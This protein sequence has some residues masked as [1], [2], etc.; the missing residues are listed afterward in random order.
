M[1][2]LLSLCQ[3]RLHATDA[4]QHSLLAQKALKIIKEN[5]LD[6]KNEKLFSRCSPHPVF[7]ACRVGNL[8]LV[9]LFVDKGASL[10]ILDDE[11]KTPL[12]VA[13]SSHFN[14]YENILQLL[15]L[16]ADVNL[17]RHGRH[18]L[19]SSFCSMNSKTTKLLI[20]H[21]ADVNN[22]V[23]TFFC[24][25]ESLF[26]LNSGM[27][28]MTSG[29]R[30]HMDDF[31]ELLSLG[32]EIILAGLT[33]RTFYLSGKRFLGDFLTPTELDS[34]WSFHQLCLF[35]GFKVDHLCLTQAINELI[36]SLKNEPDVQ[37]A[38]AIR[39]KLDKL[40]WTKDFLQQPLPLTFIVR[41]SIRGHLVSPHVSRGRHINENISKLPLPSLAKDFL[42]L[43][44]CSIQN[45]VLT[46]R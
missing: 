26:A 35:L 34:L 25:V 6:L 14:S 38:K 1:E 11:G 18:P 39:I 2:A 29:I 37:N 46:E 45:K 22:V 9:K 10:N 5:E 24:F 23:L 28:M 33:P 7:E 43:K 17:H 15:L 3:T 42:T 12:F 44:A 8:E 30:V 21:G 41:I 32:S 36:N 20:Q 27:V 13:I 19:L 31:Q 40:Q 4:R 16:G